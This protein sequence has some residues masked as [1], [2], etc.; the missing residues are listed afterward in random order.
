VR[1]VAVFLCLGLLAAPAAAGALQAQLLPVTGEVR[2]RNI[3]VNPLNFVFY[4]VKSPSGSLNP[5][6]GSW[7]SI[8]DNYDVSGNGL[9]DSRMDWIKIAAASQELAEGVPVGPGGRLAAQQTIS[10]GSIWNQGV[11]PF[12]DL[13]FNIIQFNGESA[14]VHLEIALD[15]DYYRDGIVDARDYVAWRESLSTQV[16]P[17]TGADGNGD[18]VVDADDYLVWR[19]SFGTSLRPDG[20]VNHAAASAGAFATPEPSACLL[21][22]IGALILSQRPRRYCQAI[23]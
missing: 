5:S 19:A 6:F 2:L 14:N 23:R 9:V 7:R 13:T 1:I 17:F 12:P 11:A 8:A 15:G 3:D 4:S 20:G 18:G 10:L 16:P 22:L 21:L